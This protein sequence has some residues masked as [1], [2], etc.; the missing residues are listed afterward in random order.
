MLLG[1]HRQGCKPTPPRI[2]EQARAGK[3]GNIACVVTSFGV[4]AGIAPPDAVS[5][6][7][8][9]YKKAPLSAQAGATGPG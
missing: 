7:R 2:Q 8:F 6:G 5:V 1:D 3:R 4:I 9:Q